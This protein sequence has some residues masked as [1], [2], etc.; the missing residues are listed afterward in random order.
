MDSIR[1]DIKEGN[2]KQVYVLYGEEAYLKQVYKRSLIKALG[3]EEDTM[4]YHVFEGKNIVPEQL[5]D[6][7]ET[8][9]FFSDRRV[10]LLENTGFFKNKCEEF[11]EYLKVLP[12]YVY[13]IFVEDSVDGKLKMTRNAKTVG[14]VV[15]FSTQ[16]E[17]YLT[18]RVLEKLQQNNLK[19]TK[20]NMELFLA[21]VGSDLG[22]IMME[23]EKLIGYVQGRN[24]IRAEDIQMI[25]VSQLSN[26][27][28]DMVRAVT[29][30]NQKQALELY[31][32]LLARQEKPMLILFLLGRQF[33]QILL[34]KKMG[35]EGAGQREISAKLGVPNFAASN[36]LKCS[37]AYSV[38]KLEEAIADFADS[39]EA[40]KSGRL[41]ERLSVEL[42]IVKYCRA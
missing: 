23:L 18:R 21:M 38:E 40:V 41:D 8:M 35:L 25:C 42:L 36:L 24:E 30:R 7:C 16:K 34:A 1:K 29:E 15:E 39:E 12:E 3:I 5:I 4:N 20:Q 6:L 11:A 33:R 28:F 37:R 17:E 31:S 14:R 19:I 2:F 27:I 22:N 26:K 9:P 13:I 10:L 32:D